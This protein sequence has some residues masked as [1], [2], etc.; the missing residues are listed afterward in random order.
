VR[1]IR[2]VIDE[3][4]VGPHDLPLQQA[5]LHVVL[6]VGDEVPGPSDWELLAVTEESSDVRPGAHT[7]SMLTA[8]GH[9][10]RGRALVRFSDGHRHLLRGDG[11]LGGVEHV[12]G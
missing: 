12:L 3:V 4:V 10:L 5:H 2:V 8:D 6:R 1:S 7:V 11:D 9:R